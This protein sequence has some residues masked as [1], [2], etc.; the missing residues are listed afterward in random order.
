MVENA[1]IKLHSTGTRALLNFFD[2]KESSLVMSDAL[3]KVMMVDKALCSSLDG[4]FCGS[5]HYVQ[6]RQI[7]IQSVHFSENSSA[8][9]R[10]KVA[11]D[12]SLA[13]RHSHHGKW[14]HIVD[15]LPSTIGILSEYDQKNDIW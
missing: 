5:I 11:Q 4:N 8:L 1:E 10:P 2:C 13:T 9:S 7:L 12:R 6:E 3:W 15:S 14:S